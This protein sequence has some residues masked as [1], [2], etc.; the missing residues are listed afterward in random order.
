MVSISVNNGIGVLMGVCVESA[1]HIT[2]SHI[3]MVLI[4]EYRDGFHFSE[5]SQ[6]SSVFKLSL[7]TPFTGLT[8]FI[9][10]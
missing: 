2:L 7:C 9:Y 1:E 4:C 8:K 10:S 6:F 5:R 3:I